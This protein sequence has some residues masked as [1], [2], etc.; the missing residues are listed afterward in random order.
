MTFTRSFFGRAGACEQT[1]EC[2]SDAR[3]EDLPEGGRERQ[4][5]SDTEPR[6]RRFR[7]ER[8][9]AE[10]CEQNHACHD[11]AERCHNHPSDGTRN[12]PSL[13]VFAFEVSRDTTGQQRRN[14]ENEW[15]E[16]KRC[17]NHATDCSVPEG[18]ACQL[19]HRWCDSV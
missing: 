10:A 19:G 7:A 3:S 14:E 8:Q 15:N 2:A 12:H 6:E 16:P 11:G 5:C 1:T 17:P 4:Q 18:L 9:L 13:S